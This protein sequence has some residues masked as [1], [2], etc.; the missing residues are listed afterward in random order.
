M[1]TPINDVRTVGVPVTDRERALAFYAETLGF[2]K[3]L[4]VPYAEGKR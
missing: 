2:E 4:N 3:R 1:S